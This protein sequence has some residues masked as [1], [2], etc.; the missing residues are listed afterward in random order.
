MIALVGTLRIRMP[1]GQGRVTAIGYHSA[2]PGALALHP[3]GTQANQ[4]ALRRLAHKLFGTGGGTLRYFAISGGQGPATGELDVGA[5]AGTD[6][7]SPV[8]GTVVGVSPY[9]LNG[10]DYGS[11][12]DIRPD[13]APSIVVSLTHLRP[14]PSLTVGSSLASSTSKVGTVIDFSGVEDQALARYTQDPGNHVAVQVYPA[15]VTLP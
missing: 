11:R 1:V 12:I 4:G 6:A 14:D 13:G 10:R 15:A 8:D 2:G 9:V 5:A 7:Y 3:L